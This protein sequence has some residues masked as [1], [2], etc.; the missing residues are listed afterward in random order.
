[1]LLANMQSVQLGSNELLST[2]NITPDNT[3]NDPNVPRHIHIINDQK[4][5]D[6][7]KNKVLRKPPLAKKTRRK[8]I[9]RKG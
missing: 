2:S 1:M 3:A 5:Q 7:L 4:G 8:G 9:L 6:T